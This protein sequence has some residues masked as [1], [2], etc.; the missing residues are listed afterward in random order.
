MVSNVLKQLIT[1]T[2]WGKLD[3]LIIDAPP[4]TGDILITLLQNFYISGSLV[5]TTPQNVAMADVKK[6]IGMLQDENIGIPILGIIENMA[7][8]TPSNHPDEKYFLFGKGGGEILSKEFNL[9]LLV[10]IPLNENISV[11]CDTGKVQAIFHDVNI[12]KAFELLAEK[13]INQKQTFR[14]I[15]S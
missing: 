5:V 13:V 2:N 6:A 15:K 14:Y 9:P 10:Q 3:Y 11:S 1:E 12:E 7:W 4:R 8:F